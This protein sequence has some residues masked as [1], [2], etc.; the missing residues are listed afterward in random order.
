MAESEFVH[1]SMD[2]GE[3]RKTYA[4]FWTLTK[5]SSVLIVIALVLLAFTRTNAV[6]CKN[7]EA[8]ASHINACGKLPGA[9]DNAAEA[10]AAPAGEA[11]P[12]AAPAPH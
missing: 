10:E 1:G 12:A 9:A 7:S 11:A 4:L 5:W 8:A 2:I 3:H 6:D